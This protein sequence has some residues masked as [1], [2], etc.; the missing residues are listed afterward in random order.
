MGF[1]EDV[2]VPGQTTKLPLKK[3]GN[4]FFDS[5]SLP[6]EES[7]AADKLQ[8]DEAAKKAQLEHDASLKGILENSFKGIKDLF[9]SAAP[10]NKKSF[11]NINPL[12]Q[13]ENPDSF[14]NVASK[15][16]TETI[17]DAQGRTIKLVDVFNDEHATK[18]DKVVATAS[19]GLGGLNSIFT[20]VTA[21]LAGLS[22][23]PGVGSVVDTVNR[24][25]G[26][27]GQGGSKVAGKAVDTLP[28][29]QETKDKIR[30]VM[31]EIGALTGQLLL[32]KASG[33][34]YA[35]VAEKTKSVARE[36]HNDVIIQSKTQTSGNA[37]F[38]DVV[39]PEKSQVNSPEISVGEQRIT[40]PL[41]TETVK[42]PTPGAL[43]EVP[44]SGPVRTRGVAES[45]EE[46]AIANNLTKEFGDLPQYRQVSM[47]EQARL[48]NDIVNTDYARAQRI[49]MGEEL[50]PPGI[51][52]ES[53]MM[54][55]RNKSIKNGDVGSILDLAT[56]SKLT[57]EATTMGQ[58]IRTL[59][60][61]S[62]EDPVSAIQ[63]IR[64][65]REKNAQKTA[66]SKD[67]RLKKD[68]TIKEITRSI[69]KSAPTKQ[70]WKEFIDS[71][72]C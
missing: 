31:E 32:G 56:K 45:L 55:I 13:K 43:A 63:E 48:A 27:I 1:L 60:E 65:A 46:S 47:T 64:A 57:T 23:I 40:T 72:E 16:Q 37:F 68:E 5:V 29:S 71:I 35:K 26:L 50:P 41:V 21:P 28:I 4:S 6:T 62:P 9:L 59:G 25:F 44:G 39:V 52:P 17:K 61:K 53:V 7:L 15:S 20:I 2:I 67:L 54:A 30:P 8:Q 70:T 42:T 58:R 66:G 14:L 24:A 10:T 38:D 51:F 22:T 36:V 19:A 3:S 69:R 12:T 34:I 11:E 18:V 33:D 49:A